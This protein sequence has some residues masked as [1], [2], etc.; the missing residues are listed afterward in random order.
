MYRPMPV[1]FWKQK[2][3][4]NPPKNAKWKKK[5]ARATIFCV[6]SSLQDAYPVPTYNP[7]TYVPTY[8]YHLLLF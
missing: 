4:K 3:V 8:E 5:E 7:S 1:P 2:A 6:V